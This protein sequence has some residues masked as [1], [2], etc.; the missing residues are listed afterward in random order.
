MLS[1]IYPL[2]LLFC[3]L[4]LLQAQ[5]S[6]T[7]ATRQTESKPP[8]PP[9][10]PKVEPYPDLATVEA[11]IQKSVRFIR[12]SL[13]FAG[14]YATKWSRDLKESGTSDRSSPTVI[15]IEAPGTPAIGLMILRAYEATG[16]KLYFQ[17]AQEI[18][19]ALLWSQLASG[20]WGTEH[21]FAP[22]NSR[23]RHYRRDLDAGD[24]E[25]GSRT[26]HT[27]LD[28]DKSQ[29]SF[30][31]LLELSALPE[32]KDDKALHAALK[33]GL[34]AL[35]A[36]QMPS[37]G[38]PQ[39]FS[40]PADAS[41][42]VKAPTLPKEWP[43]K[44]PDLDYTSYATLNDGNLLSVAR[45]LVRAYD[46]TADSRYFTALKKLGDF[47]ILAQCPEPQSGWAQQYD[48]KMEPAW[49]RKF[50]PP[51]IAANETLSALETLHAVWLATGDEK[52]RAPYQSTLAWLERSKL[53]DGQYA[54]FY[55]L[56]TNKPLYMVKDTYEVTYDDSN[57]PTH[58]GFKS[59]ELQEDIDRFVA[60]NASPRDEQLIKRADPTTPRGW[61]SKAKGAAKKA[62]TALSGQNKEGVWT[63]DN[64]IEGT[65]LVKHLNAL[66]YYLHYAKKAGEEFEKFRAEQH[67]AK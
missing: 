34:D 43:R 60:M 51:A 1:P 58:Y 49:A 10:K 50:E 17:A 61:L 31:F 25:S 41:L 39:G 24:T 32:S 53:P 62:V 8:T 48:A 55:E 36:A 23:K 29:F 19:Q 4:P 16:D 63:E 30:Q 5:D 44:W 57:L 37:G 11:A 18:K 35:L 56:H 9:S 28:D 47:L 52:Y 20:G 12:S 13:S 66:I 54:R 22:I 21:D 42:P 38:W 40:G 64:V 45:L 2:A 3:A 6:R 59:D 65:L 7:D 26:A 27:T 46:L 67:P 33:F 14:G 15:S